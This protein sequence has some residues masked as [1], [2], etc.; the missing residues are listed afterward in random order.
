MGHL[1]VEMGEFDL[2]PETP[3]ECRSSAVFVLI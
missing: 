1:G 3:A 2:G